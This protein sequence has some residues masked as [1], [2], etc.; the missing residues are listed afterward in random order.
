MLKDIH[1]DEVLQAMTRLNWDSENLELFRATRR[2]MQEGVP[3]CCVAFDYL[4]MMQPD[5][6]QDK[7]GRWFF[8]EEGL[9]HEI[10][11]FKIE[12]LQYWFNARDT[13][14]EQGIILRYNPCPACVLAK[15]FIQR[16]DTCACCAD[17][18]S[19]PDKAI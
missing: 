15:N 3:L 17:E 8:N 10:G 4:M 9:K 12:T 2:F 16:D 1:D 14:K 6:S 5:I 19:Y 13:A 11:H 7:A 18:E